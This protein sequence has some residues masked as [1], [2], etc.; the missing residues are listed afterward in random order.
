MRHLFIGLFILL[1]F[2]VGHLW[3][4]ELREI[5]LDDG[6]VIFGEIVSLTDGVYT[7]VS[8][9]LGT[10]KIEE[11]RIRT[12]RSKTSPVSQ[13]IP[14]EE[15][16]QRMMNDD[17]I[18]SMILTLQN[19]PNFKEILEDPVIMN[20]IASGDINTL[21]SNPKFLKLLDNPT[22]KEIGKKVQK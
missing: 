1:A 14:L 13:E 7:L 2:L 16:T 22:I 19:D 21:L 10:V 20:A 5:E 18:M 12:I 11:G 8:K 15:M 3:A 17:E 9:S 6:S 4:G